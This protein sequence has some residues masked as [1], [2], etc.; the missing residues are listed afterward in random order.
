MT[1]DTNDENSGYDADE[2]EIW[3]RCLAA[4]DRF[5]IV[6][7][8]DFVAE[9]RPVL[10]RN[11]QRRR[12][13]RR[14][15]AQPML[16][17]DGYVA[18]I[19]ENYRSKES[20]YCVLVLER[21]EMAWDDFTSRL[22]AYAFK[23][24][25]SYGLAAFVAIEFIP[26]YV[27]SAVVRILETPFP[28]DVA[29]DAWA[30]VILQNLIR[31]G[32]RGS[33]NRHLNGSATAFEDYFDESALDPE[34]LDLDHEMRMKKVREAI[35]QLRPGYAEFINRRYFDGLSYEVIAAELDCSIAILYD[36]NK[37]AKRQLRQILEANGII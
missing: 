11:H 2:D 30:T 10:W 37:N 36:R 6:Y 23:L 12:I 13:A 9:V 25:R 20:R 4:L 8:E 3:R 33:V 5:K 34:A 28:Y 26:D 21:N 32:A 35:A 29:F 16:G 14:L 24:L 1:R 19:V 27:Q 31:K 15:R 7:G 18:M 17:P 22:S